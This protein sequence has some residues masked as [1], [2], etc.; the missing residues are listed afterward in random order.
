MGGNWLTWVLGVLQ[1]LLLAKVSGFS[2]SLFISSFFFRYAVNL[3][4]F[5]GTSFPGFFLFHLGVLFFGLWVSSLFFPTISFPFSWA[6]LGGGV[7]F[8]GGGG[9][10]LTRCWFVGCG[11]VAGVVGLGLLGGGFSRFR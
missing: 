10:S 6:W 11:V 4:W 3:G 9:F 8:L 5:L 7:G 1:C 2:S